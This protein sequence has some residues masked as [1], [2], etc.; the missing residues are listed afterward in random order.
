MKKSILFCLAF[1]FA[2]AGVMANDHVTS[3]GKE[4]KKKKVTA[5]DENS[6]TFHVT[7]CAEDHKVFL[8]VGK[9]PNTKVTVRVYNKNGSL[10]YSDR[11]NAS[12]DFATI[13][14]LEGIDGATIKVSDNSGLEKEYSI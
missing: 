2:A 8:M 14:N 3:P 10:L 5:V 7:R 1:I 6:R 4:E 9:K 13:L 12:R 11:I